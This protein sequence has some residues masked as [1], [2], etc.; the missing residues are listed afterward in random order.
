[1]AER[2]A[3]QASN[4]AFQSCFPILYVHHGN[5]ELTLSFLGRVVHYT[6]HSG[7]FVED[8]GEDFFN[9]LCA[10]LKLLCI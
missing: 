2:L 1:M 5:K 10:E 4:V 9:R 7:E 6:Y 3:L 8:T